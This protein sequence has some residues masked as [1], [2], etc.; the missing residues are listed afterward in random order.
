MNT[1]TLEF[2]AVKVKIPVENLTLEAL[3]QMVFDIRQELGKTALVGAL[4]Q[5][6]ELL[7]ESRL[8]GALKISGQRQSI[9]KRWWVIF[10]T[11]G[12]Y[13]KKEQQTS[14]GIF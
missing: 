14:H 6:D 7:R 12:H 11:A 10:N 9:C 8:K 1:I 13:T 4:R 3:E 5:Y 2:K